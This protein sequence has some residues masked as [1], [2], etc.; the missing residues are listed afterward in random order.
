MPKFSANVSFECGLGSLELEKNKGT[1]DKECTMLNLDA[2][3]R[4]SSTQNNFYFILPPR[5]MLILP[6][7]YKHPR[8]SSNDHITGIFFLQIN[9]TYY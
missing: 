6:S 9:K 4:G 8:I 3:Y 1:Y 5:A 2:A 7:F